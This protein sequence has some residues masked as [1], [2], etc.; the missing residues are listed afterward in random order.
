MSGNK[1]KLQGSGA[2]SLP[3]NSAPEKV[4]TISVE[5]LVIAYPFPSFT[6]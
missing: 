5:A 6:R 2:K 3:Q 1:R 4:T